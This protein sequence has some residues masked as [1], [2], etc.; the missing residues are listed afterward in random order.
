[1]NLINLN[2]AELFVMLFKQCWKILHGPGNKKENKYQNHFNRNQH[3]VNLRSCH[4]RLTLGRA[5]L[6]SLILFCVSQHRW[7]NAIGQKKAAPHSLAFT[8]LNI[9]EIERKAQ[10]RPPCSIFEQY[11]PWTEPQ[12]N[13]RW[14]W[15]YCAVIVWNSSLCTNHT[16][17]GY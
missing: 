8:K 17:R 5:P 11:E 12:L 14:T 1:M 2:T 16:G 4:L 3:F 6:C 10:V 7:L 15:V 9:I 13:L